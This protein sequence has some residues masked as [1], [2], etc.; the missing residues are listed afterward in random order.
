[1]VRGLYADLALGSFR[2]EGGGRLDSINSSCPPL[3]KNNNYEQHLAHLLRWR[4]HILYAGAALEGTWPLIWVK[5]SEAK[6][7]TMGS[8]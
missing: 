4:G 5:T 3:P 1:M 7:K 8:V 2:P 6:Y